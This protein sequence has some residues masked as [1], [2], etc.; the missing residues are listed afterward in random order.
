[1]STKRRL[2]TNFLTGGKIE[3]REASFWSGVGFGW[4]YA[5]KIKREAGIEYSSAKVEGSGD[6]KVISDLCLSLIHI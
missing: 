5:L 6:V 2:N 1:M 4:F 3:G